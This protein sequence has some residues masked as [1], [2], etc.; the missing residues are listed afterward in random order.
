[1]VHVDFWMALAAFVL[2]LPQFVFVPL[3]SLTRRLAGRQTPRPTFR[4]V[5]GGTGGSNPL[6]S[7]G[8]SI[9]PVP[10]MGYRRKTPGF[11][12]SVSRD[13]TRERDVLA[14]S[15]LALAAFL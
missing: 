8:E 10:S 11:A 2:S 1:M 5:H 9:S 13:E 4:S 15:R 6:C 3:L 14:T 12:R 7:A